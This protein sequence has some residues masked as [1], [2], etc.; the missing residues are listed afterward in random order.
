GGGVVRARAVVIATGV[1]YRKPPLTKLPCF[2]GTGVYYG[3]T[4]VEGQRCDGADVVV[5]GGANSAGQAAVFLSGFVRHVYVLVRGAG[6]SDTISVYVVLRIR[7]SPIIT[8]L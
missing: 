7:G 5:V 3:A 8:L 2:E 6:L 1:Q 4:W